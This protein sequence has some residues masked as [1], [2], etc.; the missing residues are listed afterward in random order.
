MCSTGKTFLSSVYLLYW[1]NWS[2]LIC[3]EFLRGVSTTVRRVKCC[4]CI[5]PVE[6]AALPLEL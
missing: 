5:H 2:L 1:L 3:G 4:Y 6:S